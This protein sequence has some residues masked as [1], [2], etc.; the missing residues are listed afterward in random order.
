[1]RARRSESGNSG[2]RLWLSAY[3]ESF[4]GQ[5]DSLTSEMPACLQRNSSQVRVRSM[6]V[7][8]FP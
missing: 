7:M 1:M 4:S 3:R 8:R 2:D 6:A 5:Q